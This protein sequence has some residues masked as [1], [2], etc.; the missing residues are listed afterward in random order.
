MVTALER[1][2]HLLLG[3]ELRAQLLGISVSTIDRMLAPQRATASGHRRRCRSSGLVRS[4]IP[5]RTFSDWEDPAP[6]FMEADLVTHSGEATRQ[7]I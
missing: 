7:E 2:G 4:Q 1:H 3:E 5:V 6:G